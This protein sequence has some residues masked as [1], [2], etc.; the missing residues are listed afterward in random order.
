MNRTLSLALCA[1]AACSSVSPPGKSTC[2]SG[3]C[4]AGTDAGSTCAGV[5][6]AAGESC[7]ANA[8]VWNDAS[9]ASLVVNPGVL[10]FQSGQTTYA[11]SVPSGTTAVDVTA[12]LPQPAR[13]TL[14]INGALGTSGVSSRVSLTSGA[15]A[16]VV[17]V[18]AQGG[19]SKTY[20][21]LVTT[22]ASLHA[23]LAYLKASNT[24]ADD[25]FGFSLA[26][27]SD[28]STLAVG[29]PQESSDAKGVGGDQSN[30]LG[31]RSGAVYIFTRSGTVWAQ[32]AYLKASNSGVGHEFGHAVSL[33]A[34]G[35]TLAVGA[36]VERSSAK[37]IGGNPNAGSINGSGAV[38]VF[39]RSG[40]VWSQ[41]AYV[42]ASNTGLDAQF[43]WALA[44][45]S[46]GDA[47]AVG[48]PGEASKSAGVNGTQSDTTAPKAGAVYLFSRNVAV[49][50]QNAY[51][52]ASNA[53]AGDEFGYAVSISADGAVV[54]VG[55]RYESSAS[56]GINATQASEAASQ[57]GAVYIFR[58]MGGSWAQEA[59]V[60]A[61]NT[62]AE[63]GF[64]EAL[65]L[66]GDGNTLAVGAGNEDSTATGIAGNQSDNSATSA[67]AV[68]L[69]KR[70]V[71]S[72]VQEQ[73]VKATH[74]QSGDYF[75]GAVALS[76]D[77]NVLVVGAWAEDSNAVG[78]NGNGADNSAKQSGSLQTFTRSGATW[79]AL[80]YLKP[81]NTGADDRFGQAVAVSAT[82]QF[83]ASGAVNE[84]S[85]ALGV[86]GNATNNSST[87]SGAVYVFGR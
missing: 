29:A 70:D 57:S 11:V 78:T 30:N 12:T 58:S 62:D 46:S 33:S 47:L 4:D 84:D 31:E 18:T 51:L 2:D 27:S 82:G 87:D 45:S 17:V 5:V 21:A 26:L 39:S 72:W 49:W 7:Q 65:A 1:I 42:K 22:S 64:G 15:A 59:Y 44:L 56:T 68:Y 24:E 69:F 41:Q 10:Q 61:S 83:I 50:S 25:H 81:S 37:G 9:L 34:D 67:G 55:A 38:Y 79:S 40:S 23:Q 76:N 35:D 32:Q 85:N 73:Y 48:A 63:D 71:T 13:A 20:S 53:Q 77:G 86:N 28:G 60:K 80:A 75:G 3:A 6:C 19:L 36:P 16:I 66:S 43:G 74:I 54:A 8:C 14:T 52:K